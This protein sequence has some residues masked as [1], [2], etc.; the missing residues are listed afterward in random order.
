MID[1][2]LITFHRF[3]QLAVALYEGRFLAV[4]ISCGKQ[5]RDHLMLMTGDRLSGKSNKTIENKEIRRLCASR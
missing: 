2:D 1:R 4:G 3:G 5:N